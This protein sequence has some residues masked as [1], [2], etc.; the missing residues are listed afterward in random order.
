MEKNQ[1][2]E[3]E[4][5]RKKAELRER[6]DAIKRDFR[7]GLDRDFEEQAVQLENAEVL[8]ALLA[9]ALDE[10]EEIEQKLRRW[11]Q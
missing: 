11:E 5:L 10:L 7:G 6:V 4:L 8:N 1:E 9:Q 3:Q 2:T